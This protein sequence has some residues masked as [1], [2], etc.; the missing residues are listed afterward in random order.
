MI[1]LFKTMTLFTHPDDLQRTRYHDDS[2]VSPSALCDHQF[3][4]FDW[5]SFV[6][7]G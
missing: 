2:A 7:E 4:C 1:F 3:L 5:E 6:Q